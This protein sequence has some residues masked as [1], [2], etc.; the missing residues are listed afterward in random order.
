MV[1]LLITLTLCKPLARATSRK[2]KL[3][4]GD[5]LLPVEAAYLKRHGDTNFAVLVLL[6]D[7]VHREVKEPQST[8][9]I[10]ASGN[11][12]SSSGDANSYYTGSIKEQVK[13]AITDWGKKK[14]EEVLE[15]D[16]KKNPLGL[17]KRIPFL[18]RVIRDGL[19]ETIKE[20]LKDPRSIKK[21]ISLHGLMRLA[22]EIG[23]TGYKQQL[24]NALRQNLLER[25]YIF[26]EAERQRAGQMLCLLAVLAESFAAILV[27]TTIKNPI[28]AALIFLSA[29]LGAGFI[30]VTLGAREFIPYYSELMAVLEHTH[31]ANLRVKALQFFLKVVNGLLFTVSYAAFA[32]VLAFGSFLLYVVHTVSDLGTYLALLAQLLTQLAILTC[33][34]EAHLLYFHD[35]P[36]P[37]GQAALQV[38]KDTYKGKS[39]IDTLK[40]MLTGSTYESDMSYMLAIYGPES[41]LFL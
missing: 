37:E 31:N 2:N 39:T 5:I 29:L 16:L 25:G 22:T 23:A 12:A 3:A 36:T 9:L 26:Q 7:L 15:I 38:L 33:F 19:L 28:D 30:K 34:I 10:S 40:S 35:S 32:L 20:I 11:S 27:F 41:L 13:R 17:F 6:F 18:Y 1:V 4:P 24:A 14:V 21:Y 8:L